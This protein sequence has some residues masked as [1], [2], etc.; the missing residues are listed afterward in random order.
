M[1]MA[2]NVEPQTTQIVANA[3][4]VCQI[5]GRFKTPPYRGAR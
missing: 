2:R 5:R 1:R 4:S 3:S